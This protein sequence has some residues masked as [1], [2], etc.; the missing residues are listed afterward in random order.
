MES[1]DRESDSSAAP[2]ESWPQG[3]PYTVHFP[4]GDGYLAADLEHPA[5]LPR[6]GDVVEY[7]D[8]RGG[9]HRYRVREVIQTL[10]T[11][12]AGRP[13][14]E[15]QP[16]PPNS[17]PR[18]ADDLPAEPPGGSGVIRAGLPKVILEHLDD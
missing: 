4:D 1:R 13:A 12:A 17:L 11:S 15:E 7:I 16:A 18:P 8:E 14:I 2:E 10:Q 9:D 5:W 6:V 3:M